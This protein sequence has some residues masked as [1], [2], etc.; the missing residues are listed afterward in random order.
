MGALRQL[1]EFLPA[2]LQTELETALRPKLIL[3]RSRGCRLRE[4]A[5]PGSLR[6]RISGVPPATVKKNKQAAGLI[7]LSGKGSLFNK[8]FLPLVFYIEFWR[9]AL[10]RKISMSGGEIE[11][12]AQCQLSDGS[13]HF[14]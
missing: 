14:L 12:G 6:K 1:A 7:Y 5:P 8:A 10:N 11:D 3:A 9:Q 2:A 13:I 4:K